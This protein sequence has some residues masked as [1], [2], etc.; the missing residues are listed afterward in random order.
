MKKLLKWIDEMIL[1]HHKCE[2]HETVFSRSYS[3]RNGLRS[4]EGIETRCSICGKT[5]TKIGW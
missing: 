1:K 4:T 2:K 3:E 5:V